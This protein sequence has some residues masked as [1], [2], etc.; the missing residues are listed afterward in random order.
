MAETFPKDV[1]IDLD[2]TTPSITVL[3]P[4]TH[5]FL[6]KHIVGKPARRPLYKTHY[7]TIIINI[8]LLLQ[9]YFKCLN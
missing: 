8:L 4:L 2:E 7:D 9:M 6:S 1:T 3:S 5:R